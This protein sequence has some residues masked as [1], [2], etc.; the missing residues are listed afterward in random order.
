MLTRKRTGRGQVTLARAL[1]KLG[2][3][4]RAEAR[5]LVESGKVTVNG[6]P[7]ADPGLW[8]DLREDRLAVEGKPVKASARLYVAMH[9]PAGVVTTRA[10]ERG[11][12]TVYDLLPPGLPRLFP[13][14]RLDK[15][16]SGLLLFTNDTRFGETVTNPLTKTPKTYRVVTTRPLR[17]NDRR[18]LERGM[19]L[20]DGTKLRPASVAE[21][22]PGTCLVTIHEGKNRQIRRMFEDLGYTIVS[23]HRRSIGPVSLGSLRVG[24]VRTLT[25]EEVAQLIAGAGRGRPRGG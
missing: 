8:L 14:G 9:K 4:T 11:R 6:A 17:D 24:E 18:V 2:V 5:R 15:E 10:D 23:L 19:V 12:R 22:G 3:A 20:T 25:G 16:T 1:S 7:A 21:E 13:V